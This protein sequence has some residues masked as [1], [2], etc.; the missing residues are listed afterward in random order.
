MGDKEGETGQKRKA[1]D[2]E[3]EKQA[4]GGADAKKTKTG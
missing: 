4:D 3:E 1:E 2:A